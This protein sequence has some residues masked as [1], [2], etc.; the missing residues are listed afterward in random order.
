MQKD[1]SNIQ[2]Q[3]TVYFE[4]ENV[5]SDKSEALSFIKIVLVLILSTC[6]LLFV[7]ICL[8]V[9]GFALNNRNGLESKEFPEE[10][11]AL[12]EQWRQEYGAE[13]WDEKRRKSDEE[14][15][16][17]KW[18]EGL[19]RWELQEKITVVSEDSVSFFATKIN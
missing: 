11:P 2:W 1:N 10:L 16:R 6:F 8:F 19:R 15:G 14:Q 5:S 9:V 13:A 4:D 18:N 17:W 12:L 3:N 7:L